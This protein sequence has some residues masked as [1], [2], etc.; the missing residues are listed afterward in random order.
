MFL[1]VG[2]EV[3]LE[4]VEVEETLTEVEIEDVVEEE[5]AEVVKVFLLEAVKWLLM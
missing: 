2:D 4:Q 3:Y 5:E 1:E